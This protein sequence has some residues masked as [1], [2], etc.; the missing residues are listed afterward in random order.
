MPR[1]LAI[2]DEDKIEKI[3]IKVKAFIMDPKVNI[4]DLDFRNSI[5]VSA[6]MSVL[7]MVLFSNI[8][9]QNKKYKC[10]NM[11]SKMRKTFMRN[12]FL[13]IVFK[14]GEEY[15]DSYGNMIPFYKGKASNNDKLEEY[16]E[17]DVFENNKW[18]EIVKID[19]KEKIIYAFNELAENIVEHS[20]VNNVYCCGQYYPRLK[21][22]RLALADDGQ[23]IPVNIR[24]KDKRIESLT[25]SQLI[26]WATQ[27][28]NS[29]KNIP[30]S[31]LGL[32]DVKNMLVSSGD[33]SIISNYGFWNSKGVR[34]DMKESLGGTFI[35]FDVKLNG[36]SKNSQIINRR[37]SF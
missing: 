15:Y 8:K 3:I 25:D 36:K 31:G 16:L 4:I 14:K 5:F 29:T 10:S 1:F 30:Q 21:E 23:T 20:K 24:E 13:P 12:K 6:E 11:N 32:Y 28:G 19:I 7:L 2:N 9:N 22:I 26:D 33:L 35:H 17:R 18:N 37:L 34:K 27:E